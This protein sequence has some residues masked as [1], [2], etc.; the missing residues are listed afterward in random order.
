M[1]ESFIA[2]LFP[3][4]MWHKADKAGYALECGSLV[5]NKLLPVSSG[6]DPQI[7]SG[8]RCSNEYAPQLHY[9]VQM[10]P[11]LAPTTTKKKISAKTKA[12]KQ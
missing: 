7:R 11:L 6:S 2:W 1:N 12:S 5:I 10:W 4:L 8:W 9:L 3:K